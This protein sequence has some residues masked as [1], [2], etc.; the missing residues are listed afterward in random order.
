MPERHDKRPPH[1]AGALLLV[2]G[3]TTGRP[4]LAAAGPPDKVLRLG[5]RRLRPMLPMSSRSPQTESG[6]AKTLTAGTLATPPR[7][8]PSGRGAFLASSGT[9]ACTMKPAFEGRETA[10]QCRPKRH[11][12]SPDI[13]TAQNQRHPARN[14]L[15]VTGESNQGMEPKARRTIEETGLVHH[16]A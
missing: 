1:P 16:S 15:L 10:A 7:P 12:N 11:E 2:A 8:K 9:V 13:S 3:T 6:S 14:L 4:R 5:R